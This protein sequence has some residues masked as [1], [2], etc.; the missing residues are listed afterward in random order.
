MSK[1]FKPEEL[2]L[3]VDRSI[4]RRDF[5]GSTLIGAGAG[6]LAMNAP[7]VMAGGKK[8][9]GRIKLGPL[10][11][12]WTGPGGYGDYARANGNTHEVVNTAHALRD[13]ILR[14]AMHY[15]EDTGEVYDLIIVGGGFSGLGAAYAF[16]EE[17]GDKK[18]CLILDNSAIFGGE[19]KQNEFMVDGYHLYGP[20]G[21]NSFVVNNNGSFPEIWH[22]LGLPTDFEFEKL[23]GTHKDIVFAPDNFGPM[24]K[25]PDNASTGYFYNTESGG[26]WVKNAQLNGFK[27]APIDESFRKDLNNVLHNRI[28]PKDFGKDWEKQMDS[29]TYHKFLVDQLGVSEDVLYKYIDPYFASA[30]FGVSGDAISAYGAY[31]LQMP[32]TLGHLSQQKRDSYNNRNFY[33]WP[34]GNATTLRHLV[35]AI[36]PA[37]IKGD[38]SLKSIGYGS[39]NFDALDKSGNQFRIRLSSTAINVKHEGVGDVQRV[40]VTYFKDGKVYRVK[41]K[42]VVMATGGWI[43]RR[44]VTD[45]PQTIANAYQQFNHTPMLSVNVALKNWKFMENLGISAARW[46]DHYSWY[47][48]IR[49][50]M[51]IDGSAAPLDPSKPVVMTLYVPFV[52]YA[53]RSLREQ[54]VLGRTELFA[55]SYREYELEIRKQLTNMFGSYGFD[56]KRD[57]AGLVLNRWGHAYIAPQTGF[58]FGSENEPAP[59]HVVDEGYGRIAFGHSEITGFQ[60]WIS[61]CTQGRRAVEKILNYATS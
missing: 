53:G 50:P 6:L 60:A 14:E 30:A 46:F 57:I 22:K 48:N 9:D 33:G 29:M 7:D 44:V 43:T 54:A 13:G 55:K 61:G 3:G 35:K 49:Q 59:R 31:K 51:K 20:Q 37:A 40:A 10:G 19:G 28:K 58:Y 12:D 8:N 41:A 18:K 36:L 39:I 45:M 24:M 26:K 38:N 56:A 2:K 34:G 15:P 42:A 32:G 52:Q 1:E 17:V 16:K 27:D 21:S 4:T 47:A 5:L 11:P 25:W 23:T